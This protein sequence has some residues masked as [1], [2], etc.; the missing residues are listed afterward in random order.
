MRIYYSEISGLCPE[1]AAYPGVSSDRNSPF[2]SSLLACACGDYAKWYLPPSSRIN[3][4]LSLKSRTDSLHYSVSHSKAHVLVGVSGSHPLG[5]DTE[6]LDRK[7]SLRLAKAISEGSELAEFSVLEL[8]CL[9]ESCFKLL[10]GGDLRSMRFK[11]ENGRI[12]G[13]SED[14][15]FRLYTDIDGAV[16]AACSPED[17]LPD[18]LIHISPE[19]LLKKPSKWE[20]LL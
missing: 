5:V 13:P 8:W 4:G 10:R 12:K 6:P 18:S 1:D 7:V 11:R 3:F 15:F 16:A 9:K 2:G 17:D 20:V 14:M 19:K